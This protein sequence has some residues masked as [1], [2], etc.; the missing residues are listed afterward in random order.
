[1]TWQRVKDLTAKMFLQVAV[2]SREKFG[3]GTRQQGITITIFT[4]GHQIRAV[5]AL[6]REVKDLLTQMCKQML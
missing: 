2:P 3:T 4:L 1:M 5:Y 6:W